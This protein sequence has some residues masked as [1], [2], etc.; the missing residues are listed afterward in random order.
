M[1]YLGKSRTLIEWV[2]GEVEYPADG[3][4]YIQSTESSLNAS[5]PCW[6]C[7]IESIDLSDKEYD[8]ME[9]WI[10]NNGY[11]EFLGKDQLEDI[12]SN[13]QQQVSNFSESQLIGAIEYY[14]KNDAFICL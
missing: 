9:L 4:L 2:S 13:L 8:E 5:T 11:M 12:I 3:L 1:K 14:W 7:V 6:P 10:E